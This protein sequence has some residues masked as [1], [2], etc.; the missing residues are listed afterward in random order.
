MGSCDQDYGDCNQSP[1][2][3]CKTDLTGNDAHCGACFN[4]CSQDQLCQTGQCRMACPAGQEPCGD[5]CVSLQ[6][7]AA[8]CGTCDNACSVGQVCTGGRCLSPMFSVFGTVRDEKTRQSL[9]GAL[10]SLDENQQTVSAFDG[11]F[12]FREVG[13]ATYQLSAVVDGYQSTVVEIV[14]SDSDL[15]QD[16]VLSAD[17]AAG[18]S[19]AA[20]D[21][22]GALPS[23]YLLAALAMVWQRSR[24]K[25]AE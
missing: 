22:G 15:E 17:A 25:R 3:G 16:L 6:T 4:V 1:A 18:C 14:V 8:N 10:V 24:R 20:G 12:R 13:P 2:D 23:L 7:D 21:A 5:A 9:S 11:T 19:C